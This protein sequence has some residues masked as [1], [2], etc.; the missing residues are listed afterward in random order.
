MFEELNETA[1]ING[2]KYTI[3]YNRDRLDRLELTV[4]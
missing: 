2:K 1:T 4:Q 3:T